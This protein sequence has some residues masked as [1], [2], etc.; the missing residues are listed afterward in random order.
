MHNAESVVLY[1]HDY[2]IVNP[3]KNIVHDCAL[4]IPKGFQPSPTFK[5]GARSFNNVNTD[6]QIL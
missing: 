3:Y 1:E 2:I 4:L 6:R 5:V